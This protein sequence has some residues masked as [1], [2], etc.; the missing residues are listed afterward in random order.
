ME[1]T[2]SLKLRTNLIKI[3]PE[4]VSQLRNEEQGL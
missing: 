4:Q 3:N 1:V 2:S